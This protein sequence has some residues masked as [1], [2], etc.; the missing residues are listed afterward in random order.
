MHPILSQYLPVTLLDAV[1]DLNNARLL[2]EKSKRP[3]MASADALGEALDKR[4]AQIAPDAPRPYADNRIVVEQ[5][6]PEGMKDVFTQ[7]AS[8]LAGNQ[9]LAHPDTGVSLGHKIYINPE[10]DRAY[11]AHE[12][13][14][15]ATDSTKIGNMVRGLRNNPKLAISLAMASG[16][17][18]GTVAAL[19]PGDE[20]VAGAT[21]LAIATAAPT[22]VDEALSTKNA[23]AIMDTADMRATLGQR[24]KLAGGF[25]SY[26]A[27][28]LTVG[29]GASLT[30]NIFDA[31]PSVGELAP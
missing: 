14:H 2:T 29:L 9:R 30:G 1:N 5:T 17:V 19:T 3:S 18:P 13:G 20:D 8:A 4:V 28:P 22:L 31:E 26:L 16:L 27:K 24:G 21:A 11:F 15:T 25:L 23:L 6:V 12:L 7:G 10:A